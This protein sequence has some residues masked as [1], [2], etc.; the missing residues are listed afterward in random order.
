[1]NAN[2]PRDILV[3]AEGTQGKEDSAGRRPDKDPRDPYWD[4]SAIGKW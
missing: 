2:S 1:M 3:T 4:N